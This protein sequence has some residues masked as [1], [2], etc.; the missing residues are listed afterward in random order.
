MGLFRASVA[1]AILISAG[2]AFATKPSPLPSCMGASV[3]LTQNGKLTTACIVFVRYTH[4]DL[5]L[6]SR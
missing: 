5:Y 4:G 2:L 3:L 6:T 1:A